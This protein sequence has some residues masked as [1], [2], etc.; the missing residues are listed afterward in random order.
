MSGDLRVITIND[1]TMP[2]CKWRDGPFVRGYMT[3]RFT[4][5]DIFYR[6]TVPPFLFDYTA[7]HGS[8]QYRIILT[9]L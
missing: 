5:L 1:V 4:L 3:V 7:A 2:R 8:A 9:G 6:Y